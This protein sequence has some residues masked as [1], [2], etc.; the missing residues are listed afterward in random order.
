MSAYDEMTPEEQA[1]YREGVLLSAAKDAWY[2]MT[3]AHSYVNNH[4]Y[5]SI[6]QAHQNAAQKLQNAI[7]FVEKN[8]VR[9]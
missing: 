4:V 1:K 8:R 6:E 3:H 9:S 2:I 7:E 5:E